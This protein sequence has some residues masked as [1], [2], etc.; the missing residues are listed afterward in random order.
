MR[1]GIQMPHTQP[2]S[3]PLADYENEDAMVK[4]SL[5][6]A[7]RY[8]VLGWWF[9]ALSCVLAALAVF[10]DSIGLAVATTFG[11][12]TA[13]CCLVAESGYKKTAWVRTLELRIERMGNGLENAHE[14]PGHRRNCGGES[15]AE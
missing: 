8:R 4:A 14:S 12:M 15:M 10:M 11:G 13:V 6:R 1:S 5:D 2:L 9:F 3:H 7:A